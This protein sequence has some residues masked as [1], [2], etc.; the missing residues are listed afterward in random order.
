M[1]RV[2]ATPASGHR[3]DR[4]RRDGQAGEPL[5]EAGVSFPAYTAFFFAEGELSY[6]AALLVPKKAGRRDDAAAAGGGAR[7]AGGAA[8]VGDARRSRAALRGLAEAR[9]VKVGDLFTPMRVAVTGSTA[10]PPLFET[11][12]VLGP[13]RVLPRLDAAIARLTP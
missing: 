9:G 12:A 13:E 4:S 7:D 3:D 11:L 5:R 10:S 8:A 1:Q 2:R 6:D